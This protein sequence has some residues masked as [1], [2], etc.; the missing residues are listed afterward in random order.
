MGGDDE[1]PLCVF[2]TPGMGE[3]GRS[4]RFF[5]GGGA[6]LLFLPLSR[7]DLCSLC[8]GLLLL[9]LLLLSHLHM[10]DLSCL[11]VWVCTT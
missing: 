9:L 6:L 1:F 4:G 5:W 8:L 2:R 11:L 7:S 10:V 3:S